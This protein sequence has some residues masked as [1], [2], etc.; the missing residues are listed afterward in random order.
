MKFFCK[1]TL[2][3][4]LALCALFFAGCGDSMPDFEPMD[5]SHN[6]TR[7]GPKP[8]YAPNNEQP[9]QAAQPWIPASTQVANSMTP[10]N[11]PTAGRPLPQNS[12]TPSTVTG[13]TINGNP[14]PLNYQ[15]SAPAIVY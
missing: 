1:Y 7:T 4:A 9:W 13:G 2:N 15:Q 10:A 5:G 11:D 14:T 8:T 6:Y 3:A 12:P